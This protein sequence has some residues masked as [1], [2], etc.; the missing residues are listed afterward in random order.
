[1]GAAPLT[2]P[3]RLRLS[4]VSLI[5]AFAFCLAGHAHGAPRP[6]ACSVKAASPLVVNVRDQG[7]R[8]DGKTDD[9]AAIQKAID[10]VAGTGG[11][12][13]VP[14]G[15]YMVTG[16]GSER[17]TLRSKMT[18]K[19]ADRAILKVIPNDAKKYSVLKIS[20]ASDV[21][22][23]GGTLQGDRFEHKTKKG[24]WG[25]GI[26]IGRDAERVTVVGV[27]SR[28]MW[29]DGFYVTHSNNVALCSVVAIRNRR[30]GLSII[31]AR[32]LLVTNSIFRDTHGTRPSAGIDI[33]PNGPDQEVA[34]VRIEYSKF[35]DN[36]G[37]GIM[38]AGKKGRVAN[39]QI[40]HNV[41]EGGRPILIE[42]APRVHSTE[43]CKNR[44]ISKQEHTSEGFN[45]F[46]QPVEAVALQAD[47]SAGRDM[48][49]EVN[50]NT[51]KK[52]KK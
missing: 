40:R 51:K 12:V 44:Y 37:D 50:R 10:A 23:V 36:A 2:I 35:I 19:L 34:D 21:A 22:V 3:F 52:K 49:F 31:S 15:V 26:F 25:M 4:L 17:L 16:V 14:D 18:I 41:F 27:T 48:R 29:G 38:I 32:N 43:I 8:G 33:E 1:M 20:E 11:T 28:D 46:A 9:T 47:C 13:Y 39:V 7:A 42:N 30:Q 24:Q 45:S 5:A 6:P